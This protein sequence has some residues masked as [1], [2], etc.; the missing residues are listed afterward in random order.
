M[1]DAESH[2]KALPDQGGLHAGICKFQK[3]DGVYGRGRGCTYK[4]EPSG[5]E[6][7]WLH[8]WLIVKSFFA[9]F[10]FLFCILVLLNC[11]N[12]SAI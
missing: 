4:L 7:G 11:T 3:F 1:T 9:E 10:D 2:V 12:F 5:Y 8:F 6:L